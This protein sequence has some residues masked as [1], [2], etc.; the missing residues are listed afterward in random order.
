MVMG[1][2][3][4]QVHTYCHTWWIVNCNTRIVRKK[5]ETCVGCMLLY[6][7]AF[8]C[9]VRI[10]KNA[11]AKSKYSGSAKELLTNQPT[12]H[13]TKQPACS[14]I[15][16]ACQA[17][18]I[19]KLSDDLLLECYHRSLS[20]AFEWKNTPTIQVDSH[21]VNSPVLVLVM[22][23]QKQSVKVL[24]WKRSMANTMANT[25]ATAPKAMNPKRLK[26]VLKSRN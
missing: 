1:R 26:S 15:K 6:V 7:Q 25:L 14:Y 13:A 18:N 2:R 21:I 23:N 24:I 17:Q 8:H 11:A 4:Q 19:P 16:S 10:Y 12:N 3:I 9:C 20:F 5:W 22:F